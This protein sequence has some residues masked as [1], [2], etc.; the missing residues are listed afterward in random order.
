MFT[1]NFNRKYWRKIVI[2]F[3]FLI[4]H[5]SCHISCYTKETQR[6][7]STY[8]FLSW[9]STYVIINL[10]SSL[11]GINVNVTS[12]KKDQPLIFVFL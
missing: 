10:I 2:V 6:E 8:M 7:S 11:L 12:R 5:M 1:R 3:N 4:F 9:T